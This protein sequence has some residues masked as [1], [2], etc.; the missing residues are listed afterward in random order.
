MGVLEIIGV[1]LGSANVP[2]ISKLLGDAMKQEARCE[3]GPCREWR[4][5]KFSIKEFQYSLFLIVSIVNWKLGTLSGMPPG[6]GSMHPSAL[7]ET[8]GLT[9]LTSLWWMREEPQPK[10]EE[11]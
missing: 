7:Y 6:V 3:G 10:L 11:Q 9:V 1:V 2:D 4:L 8:L 5:G